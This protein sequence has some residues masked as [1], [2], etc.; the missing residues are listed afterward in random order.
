MISFFKDEFDIYRKMLFR[1]SQKS[2]AGMD[3]LGKFVC[4]F[5]VV[6]ILFDFLHNKKGWSFYD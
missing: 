4:D 2:N 1:E 5:F 6:W 3:A